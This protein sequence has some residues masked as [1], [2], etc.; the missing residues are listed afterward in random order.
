MTEIPTNTTD[1]NIV[2]IKRPALVIPAHVASLRQAEPEKTTE[3]AVVTKPDRI[4]EIHINDED[5]SVFE[6]KGTLAITPVGLGV[7]NADGELLVMVPFASLKYATYT[8]DFADP[9]DA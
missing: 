9:S 8:G 7:G 2:P 3:P 6:A 5:K 4:F 1:T